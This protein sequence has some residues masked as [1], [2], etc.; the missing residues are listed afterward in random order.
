MSEF[1]FKIGS[2]EDQLV[3]V[4]KQIEHLV[5]NHFKNAPKDLHSKYGMMQMIEKRKKLLKYLKRTQYDLYLTIVKKL[6]IRQKG[7]SGGNK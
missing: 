2:V 6:G 5:K 1:D 3:R 7:V 4:H